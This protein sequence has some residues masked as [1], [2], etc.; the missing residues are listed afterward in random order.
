MRTKV[1][2]YGKK[3]ASNY[4]EARWLDISEK[5]IPSMKK[6][7]QAVSWVIHSE[8][9]E[10]I[11][12]E[13]GYAGSM[14][15]VKRFANV[16][17]KTLGENFDNVHAWANHPVDNFSHGCHI[18]GS[19]GEGRMELRPGVNYVEKNEKIMEILKKRA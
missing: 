12:K 7:Q 8:E 14:R 16:V 18:N 4:K 3:D 5:S 6:F 1:E 2:I 11:Q 10:T 13:L 9:D 17:W 15:D 19:D